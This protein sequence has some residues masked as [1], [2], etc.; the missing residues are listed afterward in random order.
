MAS[1]SL[2]TITSENEVLNFKQRGGENLKDACY[3]ICDAHNR[4]TRKQPPLFFFAIF[5]WELLLGIDLCLIL[6]LEGIS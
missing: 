2:V 4:S 5:M 1:S 6:L 3:R